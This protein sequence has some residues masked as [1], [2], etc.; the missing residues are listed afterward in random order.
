L[1]R[2]GTCHE[3]TGD[4]RGV[5]EDRL[6]ELIDP[7]LR[8]AGGGLEDGEEFHEPTLD[9]LRYYRRP[10][11]WNPVPVLGRAL[12]VVAVV[13][14][15]LDIELAG[16]GYEALLTR[17]AGAAGSR[18]PPWKG[19]VIGLTA[20][21][22]TAEPIGPGD[23]VLLDRALGVSLRRF[24]VITFGILRINLGQEAIA[25]ALKSS[26]YQLFPEPIRLADALGE[27]F[28]RFVPLIDM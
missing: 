18:F 22:L 26:P 28:R 15:P 6:L 5:I 24:R 21:V 25:W 3:T 13:R 10:V 11:R 7:V 1:Y 9:V 8:S 12:S 4:R 2:D 23:G 16:A 14:Q 27:H 17:L 20:L 19:A